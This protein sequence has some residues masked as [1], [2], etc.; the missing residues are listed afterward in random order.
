[1][2]AERVITIRVGTK[3]TVVLPDR[4]IDLGHVG[5]DESV[6]LEAGPDGRIAALKVPRAQA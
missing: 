2:A 5:P 1:M 4:E 6:R 3:V